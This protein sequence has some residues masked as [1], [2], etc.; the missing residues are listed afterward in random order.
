[1][2]AKNYILRRV[3]PFAMSGIMLVTTSVH[4]RTEDEK[5]TIG[6]IDFTK[7]VIHDL[8]IKYEYETETI[9]KLRADIDYVQ[10]REIEEIGLCIEL[11]GLHR[12]L[13]ELN[14]SPEQ[15]N[16]DVLELDI[17]ESEE[18]INLLTNEIQNEDNAEYA[19]GILPY[20]QKRI[21]IITHAIFAIQNGEISK[22]KVQ[23]EEQEQSVSTILRELWD[24]KDYAYRVLPSHSAKSKVLASEIELMQSHLETFM[25][26]MVA[27]PKK[28][29]ITWDKKQEQFAVAPTLIRRKYQK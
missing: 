7:S 11:A 4:P 15:R 26:E 13:K 3:L 24:M 27:S 1:M 8:E 28:E 18:E 20:I 9:N 14:A 22:L 19:K 29:L 10:S 16:L 25:K 21:S 17:R 2:S 5:A 12:S 23:F 6:K